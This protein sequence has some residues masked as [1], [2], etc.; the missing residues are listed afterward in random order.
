MAIMPTLALKLNAH[1]HM[2]RHAYGGASASL[3]GLVA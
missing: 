1:S 3:L 2:L